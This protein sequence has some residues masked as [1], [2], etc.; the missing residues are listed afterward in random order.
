MKS[1]SIVNPPSAFLFIFSFYKYCYFVILTS[2]LTGK[3]IFFLLSIRPSLSLLSVSPVL[4]F[5]YNPCVACFACISVPC[6]SLI[7]K[8]TN[9]IK[10]TH[11]CFSLFQSNKSFGFFFFRVRT[12]EFS[13][14]SELSSGVQVRESE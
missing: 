10:K 2:V 7:I 11:F 14:R 1:T 5:V 3:K 4:I 12:G 13:G 9:K 6:F 8:V